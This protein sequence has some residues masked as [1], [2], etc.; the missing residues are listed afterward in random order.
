MTICL[1]LFELTIEIG[2]ETTPTAISDPSLFVSKN[3]PRS[4]VGF[5]PQQEGKKAENSPRK[6]ILHPWKQPKSKPLPI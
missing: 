6:K 3:P 1:M 5:F 2:L 4:R